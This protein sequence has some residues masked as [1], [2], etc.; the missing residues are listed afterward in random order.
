MGREATGGGAKSDGVVDSE[1]CGGLGYDS[2]VG[3]ADDWPKG[4]NGMDV[5]IVLATFEEKFTGV[6]FA[7]A[8]GSKGREEVVFV[9]KEFG[10]IGDENDVLFVFE[11][12]F[13]NGSNVVP[14]FTNPPLCA[15]GP[16]IAKTPGAGAA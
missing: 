5:L 2:V 6:W 7:V 4:S 14:G 1:V 15:P 10:I 9:G 12:L 13:A 11:K 16:E 3:G 8:N